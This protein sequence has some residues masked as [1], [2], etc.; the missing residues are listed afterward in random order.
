MKS[1][2]PICLAFFLF[3]NLA[4]AQQQYTV[5][6]ENYM[7]NTEVEGELTLLWNII[8]GEYRYFSKKENEIV[9]LKNTHENGDY[10]EEYKATLQQQTTDAAMET[11]KLKLTLPDLREFFNDYNKQKDP[12]FS[13]EDKSVALLFRLGGFAG[14][15]NLVYTENPT[16]AT[17]PQAGLEL[18][19]TDAVIL[20]RHALVFQFRQS[21]KSSEYEY[22]SSQFSMN[23][24]FKFVKTPK[25]DVF[26]NTKIVAFTHAKKEMV[27]I[28]P[29]PTDEP[30]N[31][32]VSGSN[33]EAPVAF[34]LGLDYALGNGYLTFLYSDIVAVGVD[35]NGEFPMDFV[36]GYKFNL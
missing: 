20:R 9:E 29:E 6:G 28:G 31:R 17:V 8:D 1:L 3:S 14:I 5:A 18:E 16:N 32:T 36:L 2:F 11:G 35:N 21:F 13:A 25:L 22:S 12:N 7:L 23:Y 10:L 30:E 27:F 34:G 4:S 19:L 24:R 15:S 26:I 33:L